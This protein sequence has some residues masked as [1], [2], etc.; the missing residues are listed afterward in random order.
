MKRVRTLGLP[1]VKGTSPAQGTRVKVNLYCRKRDKSLTH[2]DPLTRVASFAV[3]A[4][5]L[6]L[7]H[8]GTTAATQEQ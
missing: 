4:L 8:P 2:T 1:G 3:K 6:A 7:S 5:T